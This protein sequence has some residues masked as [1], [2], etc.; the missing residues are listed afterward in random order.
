MK[1]QVS[2]VLLVLQ[3]HVLLIIQLRNNF[4]N[5]TRMPNLEKTKMSSRDCC[6]VVQRWLHAMVQ[7]KHIKFVMGEEF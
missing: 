6:I 4:K 2:L 5:F 3:S 1:M 7:C